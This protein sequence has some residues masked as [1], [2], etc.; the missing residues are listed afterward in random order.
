MKSMSTLPFPRILLTGGAGFIGSN[1]ARTLRQ[2]FPESA[3]IIIDNFVTGQRHNIATLVTD[4]LVEVVEH[5]LNDQ[6][7]LSQF[8][9]A[10]T[11][12]FSLIFHLASPASPPRY[13]EY[14]IAT[15]LVNTQVTHQL[16]EYAT[17]N[18]ARML[19]ASTSEV[20][21]DPLVHP[22]PESYWGNVNPNGLRSCYDESKRMG[23]TIC[24]VHGRDF[25]ADIRIVRFFNTYGPGMD[26]YDGRV[27]PSFALA[28]LRGESLPMFG[29]GQQTRSFCYIDDVVRGILAMVELPNL[30]GE[31][32]N[33]GNPHEFTL[34][35][36][37]AALAPIFGQES[38][39]MNHHP[40]PADD[41]QRRRP[42][43]SKAQQ[44]LGWAPHVELAEGL[45]HTMDYFRTVLET[46]EPDRG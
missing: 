37:A 10:Q 20:Y 4:P 23:E 40:L 32:I 7:W 21:G 19:F 38:L 6:I 5:D 16:A 25:G 33:L 3:L 2:R 31:T 18:Q 24:G 39:P 17:Q 34:L 27:I 36:L 45:W 30:A 29:D 12:P 28:A 35:E 15:Y 13:Q 41:P 26:L 43:I 8:L 9:S 11:E 14:P 44:L 42:D 1:L 22:Q 46:T